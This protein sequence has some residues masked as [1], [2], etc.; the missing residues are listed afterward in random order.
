MTSIP[1]STDYTLAAQTAF[2]AAIWDM[3][4][5]IEIDAIQVDERLDRIDQQLISIPNTADIPVP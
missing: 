5:G 1:S 4:T 2:T 3:L